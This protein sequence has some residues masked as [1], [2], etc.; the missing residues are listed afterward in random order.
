MM[1]TA[2]L[3]N[4]SRANWYA[5]AAP[6]P[7][8]RDRAG[9]S[10]RTDQLEIGNGREEGGVEDGSGIVL[11]AHDQVLLA[12]PP[13]CGT[14][15]ADIQ[16]ERERRIA[17]R[18]SPNGRGWRG[19]GNVQLDTRAVGRAP[20][21]GRVTPAGAELSDQYVLAPVKAGL[22]LPT[23]HVRLLAVPKGRLRA[24]APLVLLAFLF[25]YLIR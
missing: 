4:P 19:G 17:L 9:R 20:S 3:L 24:L 21:G 7:A 15:Y 22:V 10:R 23:P 25:L 1:R 5:S 13:C 18:Q 12:P 2:L 8:A 14:R 6:D 11:V 16:D